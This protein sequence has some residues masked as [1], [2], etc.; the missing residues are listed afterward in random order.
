MVANMF[1]PV[2]GRRHGCAL[3]RIS[4]IMDRMEA[5]GLQDMNGLTFS[6][7][8]DPAYPMRNYL[9]CPFKVANITEGQPN[10]N[11]LMSSIREA[12]QWEFGNVCLFLL[13]LI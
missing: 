3:L 11:R 13:S 1:G 2:E 5:A 4:G 7:Y 10:F 9:L 8:G 6:L 12:V